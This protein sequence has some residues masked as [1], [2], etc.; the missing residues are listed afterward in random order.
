MSVILVV[1][2]SAAMRKMIMA[3]LRPLAVTFLEAENGLDAIEKLAL[4]E[5][6]LIT[7]D[8]NMPDMHGLEFLAFIRQN[9]RYAQTPVVVISTVDSQPAREATEKLGISAYVPKP[10]RPEQL[11]EIVQKTLKK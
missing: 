3:A 9:P 5:C 4:G 11:L 7:L 6:D 2:D 10:F 1:D 8:L